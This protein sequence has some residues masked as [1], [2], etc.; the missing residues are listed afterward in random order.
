M[1]SPQKPPVSVVMAAY[2]E[3][4]HIIAAI[5]SVLA[6]TFGDFELIVIN[7]GSTDS[8]ADSVRSLRDAR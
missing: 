1:N 7:D 6:Q 2:N 5:R 4:A 8:T 3:E